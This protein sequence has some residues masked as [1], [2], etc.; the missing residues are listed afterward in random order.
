MGSF[1]NVLIDRVQIGKSIQGR[2]KCDFCGYILSWFDNI[3]IISFLII[4]GRCRKCHRK[5]S[6]QYPLMEVLMGLIFVLTFWLIQKNQLFQVSNFNF[7][8]FFIAFYYFFVAYILWVILVWDL[9]YMIIP[10][11]LVLIGI[12]GT[13]IFQI[14]LTVNAGFLMGLEN[15]LISALLG[16]LV[17]SGF[18]GFLFYISKG[19]WIGGGDVKLG[20]WLGL[21]VGFKMTYF[22]LLFSYVFGAVVSVFLLLFFKKKMKSQIPFGPFLIISTY[23]IIFSRDLILEIWNNL[24]I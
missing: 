11:F 9:K 7:E 16:G 21:M 8:S 5:L 10:D 14:Y 15:N 3:P 1:A 22:L 13:F 6:W 4:K 2:S 24:I 23:V 19:K 20:F 12:V 18:F 17:V